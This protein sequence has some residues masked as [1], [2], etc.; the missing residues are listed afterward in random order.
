MTLFTVLVAF[1]LNGSATSEATTTH[2]VVA[3]AETLAVTMSGTGSPIVII[4]GLLGGAYGFRKV[5]PQ[6]DALHDRVIIIDPL[7]TG[8]SSRPRDADYS[9]QAQAARVAAAL[10]SLHIHRALIVGQAAGVPIAFR[11]GLLRPEQV[12]GIVAVN[13]SASEKFSSGGLRMALR[14]API[15]KLFG[16]EKRAQNKVVNGLRESSADPSWVT[17]DVVNA[18]TAPYKQDFTTTLRVLS[19]VSS[20]KEPFVLLPRLH[21]LHMPLLLVLGE[22]AEKPAVKADELAAMRT[23]MPAMRVQAFA[24]VGHFI[25]EER[26]DLLVQAVN[27]LQIAA[28]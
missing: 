10:D 7:G 20:A 27:S 15:I 21:E 22:G 26:P 19:A 23:A 5:V 17:N 11:L 28:R 2:V 8:G 14:L 1:L 13:G 25:Q 6:L 3:P 16:G 18:Y 9:M 24:N 4:P 12:S